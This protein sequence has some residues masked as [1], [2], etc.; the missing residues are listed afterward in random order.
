MLR[1]YISIILFTVLPQYSFTQDQYLL[2]SWVMDKAINCDDGIINQMT[3]TY[4]DVV[5]KQNGIASMKISHQQIKT[6]KPYT[7]TGKKINFGF[8]IYEITKLSRDTLI[9]VKDKTDCPR[10]LFLSEA[11]ELEQEQRKK[12]ILIKQNQ[13][14]FMHKGEKIYF[15]NRH[16]SPQLENYPDYLSYFFNFFPSAHKNED[17]VM[18]FQFIVQKDG[19]LLDPKGSI[20]CLKDQEKKINQI[21]KGMENKWRPMY[22]DG[23]PVNALIRVKVRT[24]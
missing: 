10:Y 8:E 12:D 11:A 5:F 22:I 3:V 14:S 13:K 1:F 23:I 4:W 19:K 18:L 9:L 17:C 20:S 6:D 16:N 2:K 7:L 24:N 15:A 21:I